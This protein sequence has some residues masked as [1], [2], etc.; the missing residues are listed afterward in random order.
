MLNNNHLFVGEKNSEYIFI[1]HL[2]FFV[3]AY[4]GQLVVPIQFPQYP[5][6]VKENAQFDFAFG[7]L[8]S[9]PIYLV[10]LT[11][12]KGAPIF[13]IIPRGPL[14]LLIFLVVVFHKNNRSGIGVQL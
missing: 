11:S 2:V 7:D 4:P 10:V 6:G 8:V 12:C 13:E 5:L 9:S 1:T 14:N 3:D